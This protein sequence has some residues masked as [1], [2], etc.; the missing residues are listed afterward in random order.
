MREIKFRGKRLDNKE[1]VYGSYVLI[2]YHD[3]NDYIERHLIILPN[4]HEFEVDPE[5]V[6]QYTGIKDKNGVE[7][8][9]RDVVHEKVTYGWTG[10]NENEDMPLIR[11]DYYKVVIKEPLQALFYL[12]KSNDRLA[13]E[14][15]FMRDK[16]V[17]G[18]VAN[19]FK[20]EDIEVIGNIYENPELLK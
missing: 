10:K 12:I 8:Y 18:I 11:D 16:D 7:I 17:N 9:E 20:P 14:E 19:C 13:K 3:S 5:T 4:G 1:W 2:D 6:G 15:T